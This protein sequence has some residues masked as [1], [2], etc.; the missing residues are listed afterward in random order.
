MDLFYR[1][2]AFDFEYAEYHRDVIAEARKN[3]EISGFEVT[4]EA[5]LLTVPR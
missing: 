3:L 1:L 5:L 4:L 2:T